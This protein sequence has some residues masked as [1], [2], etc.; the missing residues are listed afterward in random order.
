[1]VHLAV[2]S[3]QGFQMRVSYQIAGQNRNSVTREA[4]SCCIMEPFLLVLVFFLGGATLDHSFL[5]PPNQKSNWLT[6]RN[7]LTSASITLHKTASLDLN[8]S[9]Y[10]LGNNAV[11]PSCGVC[12]WQAMCLQQSLMS[13]T[14]PDSKYLP[15]SITLKV[16]FPQCLDK[17]R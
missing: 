4:Q 6:P 10:S 17:T 8:I 9:K 5:P 3:F 1:M 14:L 2:C 7:V 13:A 12:H 15:R 11:E 16:S